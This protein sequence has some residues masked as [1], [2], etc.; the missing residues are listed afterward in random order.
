MSQVGSPVPDEELASQVGTPPSSSADTEPF[1]E[2]GHGVNEGPAPVFAGF[3]VAPVAM[4]SPAPAPAAPPSGAG[5]AP[6]PLG[7]Q[8]PTQ[9]SV[10]ASSVST[11]SSHAS[12]DATRGILQQLE[13]IQ[14]Q[15]TAMQLSLRQVGG[16]PSSSGAPAPPAPM[17]QAVPDVAALPASGTRTST[18]RDA[19]D[20][21]TQERPSAALVRADEPVR[22]IPQAYDALLRFVD[23]PVERNASIKAVMVPAIKLSLT[24][25][26]LGRKLGDFIDVAVMRYASV[27]QAAEA[28]AE[29]LGDRPFIRMVGPIFDEPRRGFPKGHAGHE[30]AWRRAANK[31]LV[32]LSSA[33]A[34]ALRAEN[35]HA[36]V[37]AATALGNF[38]QKPLTAPQACLA[39]Y[40]EILADAQ[41][42]GVHLHP[43]LVFD[44]FMEGLQPETRRNIKDL[45]R[46]RGAGLNLDSVA[47]IIGDV[48]FVVPK[49][50]RAPAPAAPKKV[51]SISTWRRDENPDVVV[52][53]MAVAGGP[54][55]TRTTVLLDSGADVSVIAREHVPGGAVIVSEPRAL[56]G[57]TGTATS[58]GHV[59][60]VVTLHERSAPIDFEV[61]EDLCYPALVG[62]SDAAALGCKPLSTRVDADGR[63]GPVVAM[64]STAVAPDKRPTDARKEIIAALRDD[65][66]WTREGG[67]HPSHARVPLWA[68]GPAGDDSI[69][70]E[71]E[72]LERVRRSD[73]LADAF[74]ELIVAAQRNTHIP[75]GPQPGTPEAVNHMVPGV[76][77]ERKPPA[78]PLAAH[79]QAA[80]LK[81]LGA[82]IAMG[83]A[84]RW[85]PDPA[86]SPYE[87]DPQPT[88]TTSIHYLNGFLV[89]GR[90]VVDAAPINDMIDVRNLPARTSGQDVLTRL[91]DRDFFLSQ[92]DGK[93]AFFQIPVSRS[94]GGQFFLNLQEGLF[95]WNAALTGARNSP[96]LLHCFM[97]AAFDRLLSVADRASV[98]VCFDNFFVFSPGRLSS[99]PEAARLKHVQLVTRVLH[100]LNTA[101]ALKVNFGPGSFAV[102][103]RYM[104]VLGLM[105]SG[106][107]ITIPRI[108]LDAL[109]A[110]PMPTTGAAMKSFLGKL[111]FVSWVVTSPLPYVTERVVLQRAAELKGKIE[112]QLGSEY[113]EH[114]RAAFAAIIAIVKSSTPMHA[115]DPGCDVG[116]MVDSSSS[117]TG[118]LLLNRERERVTYE[119]GKD[120]LVE[121]FP[122]GTIRIGSAKWRI[123]G[124]ATRA[125]PPQHQSRGAPLLELMG[126]KWAVCE[127]F[128]L[129]TTGCPVTVF[130]DSQAVYGAI[131]GPRSTSLS[132]RAL[133]ALRDFD[134]SFYWIDGKFMGP[135]DALSRLA[136]L[137]P[138]DQVELLSKLRQ[139]EP[140]PVPMEERAP[141]VAVV[142]RG[143]TAPTASRMATAAAETPA[144]TDPGRELPG[145]SEEDGVDEAATPSE[146][147]EK[148][149]TE[150]LPWDERDFRI[151]GDGRSV[152]IPPLT[153]DGL[154]N[155]VYSP[156]G[157][158][159]DPGSMALRQRVLADIHNRNHAGIG[160]TVRYVRD[161]GFDWPG[162]NRD[163]RNLAL[164]CPSCVRNTPT[165]VTRGPM[166]VGANLPSAIGFAYAIDIAHQPRKDGPF[167][168]FLM[169]TE[170]MTGFK[171]VFPLTAATAAEVKH[172]LLQTFSMFGTPATITHDGGSEFKDCVLPA[173][174]S[175]GV[176]VIVSTPYNK[177]GNAVAERAIK[178]I[179]EL[180]DRIGD[181]SGTP[182]EWT[183][184]IRRAAE[185][186]NSMPSPE[187]GVAPA[188]LFFGRRTDLAQYTPRT[189][190]DLFFCSD[191][192]RRAFLAFAVPILE[193]ECLERFAVTAPEFV[194]ANSERHAARMKRYEEDHG[195][196]VTF[197]E[198]DLVMVRRNDVAISG[199]F[200][201][202]KAWPPLRVAEVTEGHTHFLR[203]PDGEVDYS[204]PF[205]AHQLDLFK[206]QLPLEGDD[207][208]TVRV[209]HDGPAFT[210]QKVKK[211]RR[212]IENGLVE[213]CTAWKGYSAKFDSWEPVASFIPFRDR[214]LVAQM[215]ALLNKA[216]LPEPAALV[217]AFGSKD[218]SR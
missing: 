55:G 42:A 138:C 56:S 164:S 182:E 152:L 180:A 217:A 163:A 192:Y 106:E 158:R 146:K 80:V 61:V 39:E 134:L 195:P 141:N 47:A 76:V 181:A 68:R 12:V 64:V 145:A 98:L 7:A 142:T 90:L 177:T 89:E 171:V 147:V 95:R 168:C 104:D 78:R 167:S 124:A 169:I 178:T 215:R 71:I 179:R 156:G 77:S 137:G 186:A 123:V 122:D 183:T 208:G 24:D 54:T 200:A 148:G 162:L 175:A 87:R 184:H 40:C 58:L 174:N 30:E 216:G 67:A 197:S 210:V 93:K 121:H 73:K 53:A 190:E 65:K 205:K 88:A 116:V 102:D 37:L 22:V 189:A 139:V 150:F 188:A 214:S 41:L 2:G 83:G 128:R 196:G 9:A 114:A 69:T 100:A 155:K 125:N 62:W 127:R 203:G 159:A 79:A 149:D 109:D 113:M 133:T 94:Q 34:Q 201:P 185:V 52:V 108:F 49:A 170:R 202:K 43:A 51:M 85:V 5:L 60:L 187:T 126:I 10:P 129:F 19:R 8:A 193:S 135:A 29:A 15:V 213:F 101:P 130:T 194:Q 57:I 70:L 48:E 63:D 209:N 198:G 161:L 206:G 28:I 1:Q 14:A 140:G 153:S 84:E 97:N 191:D 110:V 120:A 103:V 21:A 50:Q 111:A 132:I 74:A 173:L 115:Y 91:A 36:S 218:K 211:V 119:D 23:L 81:E 207:A 143:A 105:V 17:Y 59:S 25:R 160:R 118:A 32:A 151:L 46:A 16:T 82:I 44:Q 35:V 204:R 117:G 199:K 166:T 45:V 6:P 13:L 4:S 20:M 112:P 96:G 18:A 99:D 72:T 107:G 165:P 66:R 92:G 26:N 144:P 33:H 154:F 136:E 3:G 11:Q 176:Q 86:C 212:N 27:E 172:A 38:E 31:F 75:T 131:R 157:R